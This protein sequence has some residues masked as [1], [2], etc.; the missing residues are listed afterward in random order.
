MISASLCVRGW[1]NKNMQ[2]LQAKKIHLVGIKGVA[3]AS[4]ALCLSD[5]GISVSGSDLPEEFVTQEVLVQRGFKIFENFSPDHI[6]K[7]TDLVVYTGAHSGSQNP[8]V[9]RAKELGIPT[10]SHAQALG[11]LAQAK[12]LISVCGT[13]GKSTTSAM[14]AWIMEK[15]GFKPSFAVGVGNISGLGV[16]GRFVAD[17]GWFVAEADEYA[18]DPTSD[19]RPRFVFQHPQ[20]IVCTNLKYDHPDIYPTFEKTKEVFLEF[21]N[22]LPD[23]GKLIINGDDED[24]LSLIPKLTTKAKVMTVGTTQESD[25][26]IHD[27]VSEG[28]E[29]RGNVS[30]ELFD[31]KEEVVKEL[32]LGIPGVFN[33]MNAQ[34]ALV[35]ATL[36]GVPDQKALEA[37]TEFIGTTRRFEKKGVVGDAVWYDDYAHT[38]QELQAT[39]S[40]LRSWH[41]DK[42]V[43]VIFQPHTYSRTKSLFNEFS[44]SFTQADEVFLLDIFASAREKEDLSV[45]SDMLA[46]SIAKNVVNKSV[47]NMKTL[48]E[49][50]KKLLPR[51]NA[52]TVVM[53]LGAGDVYKLYDVTKGLL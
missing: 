29:T 13:G 34:M 7:D 37:L 6:Q 21:F 14:V 10:M 42:K 41:K 50:A 35:A 15:A 38:P 23:D 46:K 8:E 44:Q 26:Y 4:L 51:L 1:Y 20:I 30:Y 40:A 31:T 19:L 3:L 48:Q 9:V 25:F 16:P 39:L 47:K 17:S 52:E 36:A 28:G 49:A 33:L 45:S 24:I 12:K 53:T 22:T 18:V 5:A 27:T 43:V 32:K 2:L 11:E